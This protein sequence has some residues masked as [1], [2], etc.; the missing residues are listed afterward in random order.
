[1]RRFTLIAVF[2]PLILGGIHA[3]TLR[4][5]TT[6][7]CPALGRF[8]YFA[9]KSLGGK[10]FLRIIGCDGSARLLPF[11]GPREQLGNVR[12]IMPIAL[13]DDWEQRQ[14]DAALI[15]EPGA[16]LPISFTD[17]TGHVYQA[18]N[19][20]D[21]PEVRE[22]EDRYWNLTYLM[23]LEKG[24]P[25]P[26]P[27]HELL[28]K[29]TAIWQE[30]WVAQFPN[31]NLITDEDVHELGRV[32]RVIG[33][34]LSGMLIRKMPSPSNGQSL[35]FEPIAPPFAGPVKV[36]ASDGR[37]VWSGEVAGETVVDLSN[38]PRGMYSLSSVGRSLV[39]NVVR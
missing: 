24:T 20:V 6:R 30:Y 4:V 36:L 28:R 27:D 26:K 5:D 25:S 19:P 23:H 38:E 16:M 21:N 18:R 11:V 32:Q 17:A 29:L 10:V 12:P 22:L 9:D 1:M 31:G 35:T 7:D 34:T 37:I 15:T 8:E 33:T 39:V 14:A 13:P 3:Q 2:M